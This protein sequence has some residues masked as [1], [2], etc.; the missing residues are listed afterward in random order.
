MRNKE[1]IITECM[2]TRIHG[3]EWM[4]KNEWLKLNDDEWMIKNE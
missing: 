3:Q 4:I 1:W 2:K